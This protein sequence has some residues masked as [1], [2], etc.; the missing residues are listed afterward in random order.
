MTIKTSLTTLALLAA[1]NAHS[2][3]HYAVFEDYAD[4]GSVQ[5]NTSRITQ[6]SK[7]DNNQTTIAASYLYN[8]LGQVTQRDYADSTLNYAYNSDGLLASARALMKHGEINSYIRHTK[9]NFISLYSYNEQGQVTLE[10]K[11]VFHQEAADLNGTPIATYSIQYVY[12]ENNKLT[13]RVQTPQSGEDMSVKNF[14][15]TYHSDG[16]LQQIQEIK[17]STPTETSTLS[18]QY[19]PNGE[20]QTATQNLFA[21]GSKTIEM[22]YLDDASIYGP[23]YSDPVK[24]W[25]V[26]MDFFGLTFKPIETLKQTVG[27]VGTT[28]S[29]QY[30]N[31]DNDNLADSL[32]LTISSAYFSKQVRYEMKNQ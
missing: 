6:I 32:Q 17:L 23:Y 10:S 8:D 19:Y 22:T 31:D 26:D 14:N 3:Q 5:A 28:Y 25:K 2:Y 12:D 16:K 21:Q 1:F 30:Q 24:E 15:Y 18:F 7:T 13:Q 27:G 4:Q 11:Q 9:E 29:Y 20:I